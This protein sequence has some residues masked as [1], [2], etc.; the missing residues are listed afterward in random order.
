MRAWWTGTAAELIASAP[1][2]IVQ[3]LA[4]R[5]VET[6]PLNRD[7]QVRAWREQIA[8]LRTA[9]DG[10][11]GTSRVLLE[12]PLLRLGRRID[13]VILTGHAILVLEFK[14]GATSIGPADRMQADDY[15]LDLFDFH[16][17]SR[18]HPIVPIVV[19]SAARRPIAEWPLLLHAV[20]PVLE[21]NSATLPQLLQHIT[22]H[23]P[24][25]K[26][27]DIDAWEAAAYRP[28]PT[29]IEA[30]RMLFG[31]HGV[32]EIAAARADVGNLTRT[33]TAIMRAIED[34]R[35]SLHH[36][37][38]FVTGIPGAGK[39]LCGLN[40]VFGL[41]QGGVAFLTGNL[42]LVH[43]MREALARD[44][45]TQG[46][47][48]RQAEQETESAI[49]PLIGFL[50][51]NLERSTPSHE[52][53]IVFDEAQR[54]WD[55]DFGRRKFG[56]AE[57]EAGLFLDIM[58]R[59]Q[60][61]AVIVALV[62]GGQEINTGEAGLAEW[63]RALLAR[64]DWHV[65][66]APGVLGASDPRQCLFATASPALSLDPELHLH[67]S[68]RSI[69]SAAAASWVE[70]LLTGDSEQAHAIATEA[71][72]MPF[73]LTRSLPEMRAALRRRARGSR[74]AGLVCSAGARR[75]IPEGLW[76]DFP[77]LDRDAVANWFLNHWPPD[78]RA[79]DALE[80][81]VTQ[82]ACQ[83]LELDFVGLAWG[84][85]LIR[86]HDAW[87]PQVFRGTA[88]QEPRVETRIAYAINTYRVLLTRA[89]Y[90]TV[91]W[92]PCGDAADGTRNPAEFDAIAEFLLDCGAVPLE[93]A[94]AEP[95]VKPAEA[96]LL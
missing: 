18:S 75:L 2:M 9:L 14:V 3:R 39:T 68:V 92:V 29:I 48:R 59:H 31:R 22:D 41:H 17:M 36:I 61:W 40:A 19:A 57:S 20:M 45:K 70:A 84:N 80:L 26:R 34:A 90:E 72:G 44:A 46:R 43:V 88:W 53:V 24:R 86:R 25:D 50:R 5:L 28:V 37:V 83:G 55:A 85:D 67:V 42:P 63:G 66:A 35:R 58:R 52:H 27:L 51:D 71:S 21:A 38:L 12:Y 82:F 32:T 7:T 76:P 93:N 78:V 4:L 95:I 89:R 79:S 81:P 15:A 49:Q 16:A 77:H 87:V 56:H 74:R 73:T 33:T 13:A 1:E 10:L 11:P 6:H 47:S 69:R 54:A 96:L 65:Q 8:M 30:A 64:P 60:D 91:I 62:G 94:P 23:V